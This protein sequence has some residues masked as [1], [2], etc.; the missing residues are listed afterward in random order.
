M[1]CVGVL[2]LKP[3]IFVWFRLIKKIAS[4][5]SSKLTCLLLHWIK[6]KQYSYKISLVALYA[7]YYSTFECLSM[8]SLIFLRVQPVKL[9]SWI[10]IRLWFFVNNFFVFYLI[11]RYFRDR[12]DFHLSYSLDGLKQWICHLANHIDWW[13]SIFI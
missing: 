12:W 1:C 2:I 11:S 7:L 9:G 10:A 3:W 8:M 13:R 4:A 5:F 6:L